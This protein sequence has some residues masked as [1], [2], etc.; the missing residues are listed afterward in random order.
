[1]F[2]EPKKKKKKN[3]FTTLS[4]V[5]TL[6]LSSCQKLLKPLSLVGFPSAITIVLLTLIRGI[7]PL[8]PQRGWAQCG[9][10]STAREHPRNLQSAQDPLSDNL[11]PPGEPANAHQSLCQG[12]YA[13][14]SPSPRGSSETSAPDPSLGFV[15]HILLLRERTGHPR[16]LLGGSTSRAPPG[17][18]RFL[19]ACT[20]SKGRA[21]GQDRPRKAEC[22]WDTELLNTR[23]C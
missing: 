7:T 12:P 23:G 19:E 18:Q 11:A 2:A 10:G 1:M 14:G 3:A 20:V 22:V 5:S 6:L 16:G 13:R 8:G 15:L 9:L 21:E 4:Q 17:G